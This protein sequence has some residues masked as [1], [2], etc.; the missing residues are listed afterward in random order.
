MIITKLKDAYIN[1]SLTVSIG[2]H[3]MSCG[4]TECPLFTLWFVEINN[5]RVLSL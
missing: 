2:V 1:G 4:G 3:T 5:H